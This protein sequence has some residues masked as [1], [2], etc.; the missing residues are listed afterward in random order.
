MYYPTAE[1][2]L[3]VLQVLLDSDIEHPVNAG[4]ILKRTN[5]NGTYKKGGRKGIYASILLIMMFFKNIFRAKHMKDGWYCEHPY[6][7]AE[8]LMTADVTDSLRCAPLG[9]KKDIRDRMKEHGC[10]SAREALQAFPGPFTDNFITNAEIAFRG[11]IATAIR[12]GRRI[13]FYYRAFDPYMRPIR[14]HD[15]KRYSVS[16]YDCHF[17]K[18]TFYMIGADADEEKLKIFRLDRMEEMECDE[19]LCAEPPGKY[20]DGDPYREILRMREEMVDH[21]DGEEVMLELDIY[22]SPEAMEIV[23][24][25]AG[26]RVTVPGYDEQSNISHAFF[27]VRRGATLTGWLLQNHKFVKATAPQS[28]IDDVREALAKLADSYGVN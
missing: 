12:K 6:T 26:K 13:L 10:P 27:R 4:Q 5:I 24:D 23:H 17:A 18:E 28:V 11:I 9:E 3:D 15:G 14:K 21:F 8:V 19:G 16:P 1:R 7:T 20:I 22:Y 2:T 25:L